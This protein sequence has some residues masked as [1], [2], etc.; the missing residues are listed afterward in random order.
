[1]SG[2]IPGKAGPCVAG[3]VPRAV[4]L[5]GPD[6]VFNPTMGSGMAGLAGCQERYKGSAGLRRGARSLPPTVRVNV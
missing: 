6:E 1:M 3:L 2:P 4:G 5:L